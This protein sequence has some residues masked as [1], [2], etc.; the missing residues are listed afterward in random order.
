[1]LFWGMFTEKQEEGGGSSTISN[2]EE[3]PMS[4][5]TTPAPTYLEIKLAW[6][7]YK[8]G[9]WGG[10]TISKDT[11]STLNKLAS[12]AGD[13]KPVDKKQILLTS[14]FVDNK[15][16]IK[17]FA[18]REP[19]R[20]YFD[21]QTL[22]GYCFDNCKSAPSLTP[23][24]E[25]PLE[26]FE[27][28]NNTNS[29][30]MFLGEKE[31]NDKEPAGDDKFGIFNTGLCKIQGSPTAAV[32]L[33]D[34]TPG[35]FRVLPNHHDIP[36]NY[37]VPFFYDNERNNFYVHT[38]GG[39]NK[40][41][42]DEISVAD[43]VLMSRNVI[44]PFLPSKL[45]LG[46]ATM[47][48]ENHGGPNFSEGE[49]PSGLEFADFPTF[50]T[51][52]IG[53]HYAFQTFYHPYVCELIKTLNT[54]GIDGL[55]KN[56]ILDA[57]GAFKDGTQNRVAKAIFIP[58]GA[59]N[60]TAVVQNSYPVEQVDF[61]YSGVYSIYNWE[62]FF[63][64]PL[65]IATRLSQ[66][67]KF[68]EARKWFHYIFDPTWSSPS[69]TSGTERFWITNPFKEEIKKGILPI[70]DLINTASPDL[71]LQLN[72]WEQNPFKP[73]AVARLRT[74]AYMRSTIM[75]YIDNLIAWGDQLF[76]RDT[77][78]TINEATLLYVLAANMLGKKP[79]RVPARAVPEENSFST[80]QDK[81]DSFSNAKVTIQSFFSLADFS[82]ADSSDTS[83]LM[84]QFCIPKNDLLL[85]YWDIAADRLFKIRHCLNIEG[86]FRQ[87]PLFEPAIDPALLVKATAAGLDLNSVLNNLNVSLPNYRFQMILQKA[88]ELCNDVKGLGS[89]L[90]AA[91]EKKDA[92]RLSLVRSKHELNMLK[93]V[94][95]IK[96][97]QRDEAR[98]NL[99]SLM[100]SQT[101][102]EERRDY[103]SSRPYKKFF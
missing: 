42:L 3:G 51:V 15:L 75:K 80:I 13:N 69:A 32:T 78:E 25:I 49:V 35:T 23:N 59:Y 27:I 97:S 74:S 16:Y 96:V 73:H 50:P 70:E 58:N 102:I 95:D 46:A 65:L 11:V 30:G 71:D 62:L 31:Q 98:E 14:T 61:N 40:H 10:K 91:L 28:M 22:D 37:F 57:D 83:V 38:Q 84:P 20:K 47:A 81:L 41:V 101:V 34:N 26:Y 85:G 94:R 64:I 92:E 55:Y 44:V 66:N 43:G 18:W 86:V 67:Q 33:F 82:D 8:S 52:F 72:N 93:A 89:E 90:L 99:N 63:H 100:A 87:L 45:P 53:K 5:S 56:P 17:L 77:I 19:Y 39:V 1:M 24:S 54:S 76:Q 29:K 9:Q 36:G 6:S 2:P 79:E 7:E 12:T 103:Y 68:A 21:K 60:P 88:N 4:L 48:I